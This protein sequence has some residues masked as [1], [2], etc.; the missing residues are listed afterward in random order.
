MI[1]LLGETLS[2]E[3]FAAWFVIANT[4]NGSSMIDWETV[5]QSIVIATL[6]MNRVVIL[7]CTFV[8]HFPF[9][10]KTSRYA[11]IAYYELSPYIY[12]N[13]NGSLSG[14]FPEVFE[15]L[16]TLCDIDINYSLDMRSA[17]NF[18]NLIENKTFMSE[19]TYGNW[20]WLPLTQ[21]I[22]PET[23][24]NLDF[25]PLP[26]ILTTGTDVLVHRD[27]VG[28]IEKIR[29]GI[30]E[31]R[32]L[33][34]IGLMLSIL[35]GTLIWFI[36][37]WNNSEFSKHSHGILTGLWFAL[38]TMTTVGY[39]DIAPKSSIG[40]SLTVAWMVIGVIL[41]AI[42]TST[43]TNVFGELDYL[44]MG[45]KRILAMDNS[46]E[47]AISSEDNE[48]MI[49]SVDKYDIL[50]ERLIKK[51]Y[52][53]GVV[54]TYVRRNQ[55]SKL[56]DFRV[57]KVFSDV[58]I[59]WLYRFM[60]IN[61]DLYRLDECIYYKQYQLISK[62]LRKYRLKTEKVNTK[63]DLVEF[64]SEP[65]MFTLSTLSAVIFVCALLLEAKM[66]FKKKYLQTKS[67]S[68]NMDE[69]STVKGAASI[70]STA[71]L[72][73]FESNNKSSH[74]KPQIYATK[75]DLNVLDEKINALG[76]DMV[77]IKSSLQILIG[78]K[79]Y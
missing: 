79:N 10:I 22:S 43:I 72:T 34:L 11:N 1:I 63:I 60:A 39:G 77:S 4:Y 58:D 12:R 57:V 19:F 23:M 41:T 54:D 24:H 48:A 62:A 5:R 64:F 13:E 37:K 76:E 66:L 16:S 40:K 36:E 32:F 44:E 17:K 18:S 55:Q 78:S 15:E 68:A 56:N 25:V 7:A 27:H 14:I 42:L 30:F 28:P 53:I 67:A 46:L 69:Q 26:K 8:F 71:G 49:E 33:F 70:Y 61:I 51:E 65:S 74:L 2:G 47:A 59:Y 29:I 31:C 73:E 20:I 50:F 6:K 35:F 21:Y 45:H 75:D 52:T 9:G 38:V 3:I